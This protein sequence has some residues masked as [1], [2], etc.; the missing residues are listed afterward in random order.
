MEQKVN[1]EE[2]FVI[3][4]WWS[5][6]SNQHEYDIKLEDLERIIKYKSFN[7]SQQ[8]DHLINK[9]W[10]EKETLYRLAQITVEYFPQN[11]IDW[12]ETFKIVER[13]F[14]HNAIDKLE[15]DKN[16]D[17]SSSDFLFGRIERGIEKEIKTKLKMDLNRLYLIC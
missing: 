3:I 1:L 7:Y 9:T 2:G 11:E 12:K 13:H 14:Y 10:L 8:I 4:T 5:D 16:P 17:R 6:E 15:E